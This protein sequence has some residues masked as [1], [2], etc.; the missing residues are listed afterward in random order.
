VKAQRW[1]TMLSDDDDTLTRRAGAKSEE[2]ENA[3]N[4]TGAPSTSN[5]PAQ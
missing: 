1:R 2:D 5:E 3:G 4:D